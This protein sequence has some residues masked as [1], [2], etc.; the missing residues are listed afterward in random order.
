LGACDTSAVRKYH[1]DYYRPD[2]LC[3]VVV[4]GI[5]EVEL[6]GCLK[7][8]EVKIISKG[9]LPPMRRPWV[10]SP[11]IPPLEGTVTTVVEF[12]EE[13]EDS[14]GQVNIAWRGPAYQVRADLVTACT[15]LVTT[16]DIVVKVCLKA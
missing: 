6:L 9:A 13:E 10:T 15:V 16:A 2:N 14:P 5:P 8:T 3:C 11:P 4:G 12:P 1:R 7:K